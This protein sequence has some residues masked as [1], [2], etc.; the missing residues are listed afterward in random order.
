ML[1]VIKLSRLQLMQILVYFKPKLSPILVE[2]QQDPLL[3][4]YQDDH[5][6]FLLSQTLV[7][8]MQE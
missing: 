3:F 4:T 2:M 8:Y 6:Q 5:L 7:Q 1:L